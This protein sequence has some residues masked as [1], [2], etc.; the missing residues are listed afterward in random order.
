MAAVTSRQWVPDPSCLGCQAYLARAARTYRPRRLDRQW[1]RYWHGHGFCMKEV[2]S[3]SDYEWIQRWGY[4]LVCRNSLCICGRSK[5]LAD[6]V[7][8][9]RP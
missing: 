4:G 2:L 9:G 8:N 1:M 3:G 6:A 7:L 5:R